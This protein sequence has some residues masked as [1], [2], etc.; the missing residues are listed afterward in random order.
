MNIL[1]GTAEFMRLSGQ[2]TDGGEY[3]WQ[4]VRELRYRLLNEEYNEYVRAEQADDLVETVDGLLDLI[5]IAWGSLLS[6]VGE[7]KAKAAA[8]EV[9]RSNLD[10]VRDGVKRRADG[11]I[12]KPEGW[13]APDIAGVLA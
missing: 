2:N 7:E 5:V 11:K 12:L 4:A 8:Y 10:K 6:Y 13:V 1:D 9:V 3:G